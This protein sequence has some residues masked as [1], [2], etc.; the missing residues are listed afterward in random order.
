MWIVA[1]ITAVEATLHKN[2][3]AAGNIKNIHVNKQLNESY[4]KCL[5]CLI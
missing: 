1:R 5:Y 2:V 4:R 3:A